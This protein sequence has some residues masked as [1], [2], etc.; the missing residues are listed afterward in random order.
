MARYKAIDSSPRFLAVDPETTAAA[1]A[2]TVM[3]GDAALAG[4]VTRCLGAFKAWRLL[5]K[6]AFCIVIVLSE[7]NRRCPAHSPLVVRASAYM[8][9]RGKRFCLYA[10]KN[11]RIHILCIHFRS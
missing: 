7:P 3:A 5:Y 6:F 4:G 10:Q 11:C 8:F 2:E 9:E 1:Y